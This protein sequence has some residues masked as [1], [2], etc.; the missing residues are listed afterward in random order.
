MHHP[1]LG[2][3]CVETDS[4]GEFLMEDFNPNLLQLSHPKFGNYKFV[5]PESADEISISIPNAVRFTARTINAKTGKPIP[6]CLTFFQG[7]QKSSE[8]VLFKVNT[9]FNARIQM[10]FLIYTFQPIRS[11]CSMGGTTI[12][13]PRQALLN[14]Q[15]E[16]ITLTLVKSSFLSQSWFR[17]N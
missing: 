15:R 9:W 3:G 13:L 8:E 7:L 14:R 4:N 5:V 10:E 16:K 11:L 17:A 2:L 12:C 6:N 1:V